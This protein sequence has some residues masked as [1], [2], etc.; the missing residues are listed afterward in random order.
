[1]K[2]GFVKTDNRDLIDYKY[3]V[4][5]CHYGNIKVFS[6][7]VSGIDVYGGGAIRGLVVQPDTVII[8]IGAKV[9]YEFHLYGTYGDD[10]LGAVRKHYQNPI[11]RIDCTDFSVPELDSLF[12]FLLVSDLRR[13]GQNILVCCQGGHGRSGMVLAIL[14]GL[15]IPEQVDG[16]PITFI[17]RNYCH[18]AI[19]SAQQRFYIYDMLGLPI[20]T[21]DEDH[22]PRYR[23]IDEARGSKSGTLITYDDTRWYKK[24]GGGYYDG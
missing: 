9:N 23:D 7:P 21:L 17:R 2:A 16:K 10:F 20:S 4:E 6:D 11:I 8:D 19:E 24:H 13:N 12:W 1:M 15:M 18:K 22:K 3:E 14:A 5:K